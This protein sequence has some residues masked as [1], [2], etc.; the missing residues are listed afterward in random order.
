MTIAH[1]LRGYHWDSGQLGVDVHLRP[2]I[3]PEVRDV[4]HV[5]G[6]P[7][8]IDPVELTPRQALRL[9]D[10]FGLS[11]DPVGFDYFVEADEDWRV[12]AELHEALLEQL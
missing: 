12:V 10:A 11:I 2:E 3:L 4:L 6:D 1:H 5:E 8:L 9:A 7:R